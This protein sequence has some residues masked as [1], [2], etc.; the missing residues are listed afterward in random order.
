MFIYI[1]MSNT[2]I[3]LVPPKFGVFREGDCQFMLSLMINCGEGNGKPLQPACLEDS[4][5]RGVCWATV[6]GVT[7]LNN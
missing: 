6:H 4:M 7:Q 5:D 2:Y 1:H 3:K